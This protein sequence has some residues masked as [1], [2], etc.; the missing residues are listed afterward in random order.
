M[1]ICIAFDRD[2][3][4]SPTRRPSPTALVHQFLLLFFFFAHVWTRWSRQKKNNKNINCFRIVV[5]AGLTNCYALRFNA[6]NARDPRTVW[7]AECR[8]HN[9]L[10]IDVFTCVCAYPVPL[11][12][13]RRCRSR[14]SSTR[15]Y[16]YVAHATTA[17]VY[18]HFSVFFLKRLNHRILRSDL[19]YCVV[20]PNVKSRTIAISFNAYAFESYTRLIHKKKTPP[21][22]HCAVD[23]NCT[24]FDGYVLWR[25]KKQW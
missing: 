22:T 21:H 5:P 6:R 20:F 18:V 15:K 1:C 17:V 14:E 9:F 11:L 8:V 4:V 2:R 19:D 12:N 25:E 13:P 7:N 10:L 23:N 3:P 24:S 16:R